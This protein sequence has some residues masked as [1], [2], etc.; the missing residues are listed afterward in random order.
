MRES[1]VDETQSNDKKR[2]RVT[3]RKLNCQ[4]TFSR[5]RRMYSFGRF[6]FVLETPEKNH[7]KCVIHCK[8][9]YMDCISTCYYTGYNSYADLI[10]N[11]VLMCGCYRDKS[12]EVLVRP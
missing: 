7:A 2:Y 4:F 3:L 9:I 10:D 11:C 1:M 12:R 8:G 6:G 5:F